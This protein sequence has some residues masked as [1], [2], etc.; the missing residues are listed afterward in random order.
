MQVEYLFVYHVFL[1][2]FQIAEVMRSVRD[3]VVVG[4]ERAAVLQ[5]RLAG[6]QGSE[7]A[8]QG[9]RRLEGVRLLT[10]TTLL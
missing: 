6:A 7:G 10:L 2:R 1:Q 4:V 3:V 8:G 9:R 5:S